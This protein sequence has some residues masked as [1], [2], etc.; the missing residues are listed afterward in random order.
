MLIPTLGWFSQI[1]FSISLD[2]H[3]AAFKFILE[4]KAGSTIEPPGRTR[5]GSPSM[6]IWIALLKSSYQTEFGNKHRNQLVAHG[7]SASHTIRALQR[8]S[9]TDIESRSIRDQNLQLE[10]LIWRLTQRLHIQIE[11]LEL[12]STTSN[13]ANLIAHGVHPRSLD[14]DVRASVRIHGCPFDSGPVYFKL[15]V[16]T[17]G[18]RD[19]D[20]TSTQIEL[21][22]KHWN[23]H[24]VAHGDTTVSVIYFFR[25]DGADETHSKE[26]VLFDFRP[27]LYLASRPQHTV[28]FRP[29]SASIL[30]AD[31]TSNNP[32]TCQSH[33]G[34]IRSPARFP[35]MRTC[36][37]FDSGP[38]E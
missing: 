1:R 7:A 28:L 24:L 15:L 22:T 30:P 31:S 12:N 2:L 34:C 18:C 19:R 16:A 11:L 5:R 13:T 35:S 29:S 33:A 23:E 4:L 32:S 26:E 17:S 27:S 9:G 3:Y 10:D 25:G 36:P 8:I 38:G 14:F 6:W 21:H 20:P 37:L